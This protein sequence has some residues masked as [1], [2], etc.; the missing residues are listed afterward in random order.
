MQ[1]RIVLITN[2][3]DFFEYI[4]PML[5]LRKSD[6]LFTFKFNEIPEKIHLLDT[7][8]IIIN[9]EFSKEQTIELLKILKSNAT[10]VFSFNEEEKFKM[11]CLNNGALSF[12][13]PLTNREEFCATVSMAFK[14]SSLITQNKLYREMLVKKGILKQNNEVLLNYEE[15][16]DWQ[17]E[18]SKQEVSTSVLVAIAPDEKS[19]FVLQPN[20][21]ETCI[22]NNIRKNDILMSFAV[23]KYFLLLFDTDIDGAKNIWAKINEQM[24]NKVYAG[25]AKNLS[26]TRQQLVNEVL[27]DL[28]RAINFHRLIDDDENKDVVNANFKQYR[29]DF[30]KKIEQI[31]APVFY[32]IKQKYSERLFGV[33][34]EQESGEGYGI[35]SIETKSKKAV[36]KITTPGTTKVIIDVSYFKNK[37]I[38][39]TKRIS[40]NP[41]ELEEGLLSD[42]L[43]QFVLEF[44]EEIKNDTT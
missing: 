35:L 6:E 8:V 11:E 33:K 28:H 32:Q 26:K 17:V 15:I 42:V 24:P 5:K 7:S 43:E 34:F 4:S 16:L 3:S 27:N 30:N 2:D 10:L 29:Q 41:E 25:F 9:S 13:T 18:K 44:R 23:N 38:I 19:K 14:I 21:I 1:G 40:L 39:D 20:S 36:C 22:L 31:L 37:N 12:F